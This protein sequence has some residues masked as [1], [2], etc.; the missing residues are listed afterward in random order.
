MTDPILHTAVIGASGKMG[1]GIA[2]LVL[3]EAAYSKDPFSLLCIDTREESFPELKA[4]LREHLTRHAERNILRVR[5]LFETDATIV[6]NKEAIDR[7]IA[8]ALDQVNC[9]SAIEHGKNASLV[10]E[11]AYEDLDVKVTLLKQCAQNPKAWVLTNTSSIPIHLLATASG[12][13]ERL[14]GYHF[15][16]PPP[17]QKL[18]EIIASKYTSPELA[19]YAE[20]LAIRLQKT[21]VQSADIAGFIGNGHFSREIL[22]ACKLVE[23]LEASGSSFAEAL[24]KIDSITKEKLIRPMGVFELLNYVGLQVAHNLLEIM[25]TYLPDPSFQTAVLQRFQKIAFTPAEGNAWKVASKE[26]K[27]FKLYFENLAKSKDP[28]DVLAMRY[29]NHS[30]AIENLLVETKVAASIQDVG[31]VLKLGFHHLYAPH[32]VL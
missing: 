23:E 12:L 15:Y 21:V 25:R 26:K 27:D 20:K 30:K 10:F 2:L 24:Q 14:I 1:R 4:Y 31:T 13:N 29:L 28:D 18:M 11:A 17:V 22:Y 7:F 19:S 32:E 3:Q 6:S 16:N 5:A 9:S 8:I